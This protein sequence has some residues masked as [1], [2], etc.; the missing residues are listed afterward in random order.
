MQAVG[1]RNMLVY[2]FL[3][4]HYGL[5]GIEKRRIK[6]SRLTEL[7][8]PFEFLGADLSDREF[9]RVLTKT[10]KRMSESKGLLC[11]SATW[12]NPVLWGHYAD[13]HQGLCLGFEI[14]NHVVGKVNY[15]DA[16][17]PVPK[18]ID[19]EFMHQLLFTKF[20]HWEYEDEYRIYS[21]LND[22]EGGLYFSY[23][24][25]DLA[26]KKVIVGDQSEVTRAQVASALGGLGSEVEAFKARAGFTKFEVVKQQNAAKWA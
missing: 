13:K 11:F 21:Q 24:S 14:P 22:E 18:S 19:D 6:I 17:L 8:D 2:H 23:F 16:R 1:L 5:E 25:E 9:R 12:K 26:L 3:N 15:V 20:R 7:N 10:K 4:S